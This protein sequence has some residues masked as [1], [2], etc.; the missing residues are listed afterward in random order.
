[1]S[2]AAA[3]SRQAAFFHFSFSACALLRQPDG[4]GIS[5]LSAID[6]PYATISRQ[7]AATPAGHRLS[8]ELRGCMARDSHW[9][10][11]ASHAS[12]HFRRRGWQPAAT[13]SL[14]DSERHSQL[15]AGAARAAAGFSHCIDI[16]YARG[17]L[18]RHY[19]ISRHFRQPERHANTWPPH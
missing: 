19:A 12:C 1:M 13:L 17:P 5:Q 11:I 6:E 7:T 18:I 16:D 4:H 3:D 10:A 14:A 8:D 2:A 9:P 15:T